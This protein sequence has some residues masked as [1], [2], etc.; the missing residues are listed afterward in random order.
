MIPDFPL[1]R[2]QNIKHFRVISPLFLPLPTLL[3]HL[4]PTLS[5]PA[6]RTPPALY[7]PGLA[8]HLSSSIS[9][10]EFSLACVEGVWKGRQSTQAKFSFQN[11]PNN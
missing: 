9:I 11:A 7:S 8:P 2:L 6:F 10:S 5:S 3:E 1:F 4:P